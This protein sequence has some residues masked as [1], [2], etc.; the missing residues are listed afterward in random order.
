MSGGRSL[1]VLPIFGYKIAN[2]FYYL[3]IFLAR[4]VM[5]IHLTKFHVNFD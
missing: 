2:I 4:F 1:G 5:H 3:K